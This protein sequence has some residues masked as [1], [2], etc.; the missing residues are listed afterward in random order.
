MAKIY[1]IGSSRGRL[2]IVER[3]RGGDWLS[4]DVSTMRAEGVNVVVSLLEQ[5]EV[6]ELAL[7]QEPAEC[8]T[9]GI[10][11]MSFP[12]PDRGVPTNDGAADAFLESIGRKLNDGA[13]VVI[14]CRQSVGRSGLVAIGLL[15]LAGGRLTASKDAV[16]HARG[17]EVPETQ[18]QLRWLESFAA[19]RN[20]L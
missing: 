11:H 2:G 13:S 8:G 19:R 3:P 17:Y 4:D 6:I 14:H 18:A 16:S 12:I 10:E 5:P 20:P 9:A 7:T 15:I 1:W